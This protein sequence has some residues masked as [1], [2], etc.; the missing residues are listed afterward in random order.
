MAA[1]LE[2]LRE[3]MARTAMSR[4]SIYK[5][6][7]EGRFPAQIKIGER[8]SAWDS[9]LVDA[10]IAERIASGKKAA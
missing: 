5:A 10:W 7:R 2:K 8:A 9:A 1:K 3:V 4:A 6:I